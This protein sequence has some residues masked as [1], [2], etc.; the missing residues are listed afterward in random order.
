MIS[1]E[2]GEEDGLRRKSED[3]M[4]SFKTPGSW[5][6]DKAPVDVHDGTS[7]RACAPRPGPV[8]D[9]DGWWVREYARRVI[10]TLRGQ[11]WHI[12]KALELMD[13]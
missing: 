8:H 4:A 11:N 7:A 3:T 10:Y 5:C 9:T 13:E 1:G 6:Q 2:I 12:F